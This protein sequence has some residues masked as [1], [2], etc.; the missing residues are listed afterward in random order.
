MAEAIRAHAWVGTSLGAIGSWSDTLLTQV[1]LVLCCPFP[2]SLSWGDELL[3]FCN[4]AAIEVLGERSGSA[5]GCSYR[6][7]FREAWKVQGT[8]IED[9]FAS[10]H[11]SK[12]DNVLMALGQGPNWDDRYW[13]YLLMPVHED[14][15]VVGVLSIFQDTTGAVLSKLRLV[16]ERADLLALFEQAPVTISVMEGPEHVYQ[17][18]NQT[19]RMMIGTRDV[20]G[21]RV[22]DAIPEAEEQ[23]Y[24]QI[25]NEVYRTGKAHRE[26]GRRLRLQRAP[27][28]DPEVLY[29]DFVY[30]PLRDVDGRV[31]GIISLGI[32]VSERQRA[33]EALIQA[34][35]LAAVGRLASSIAHEINNP[36]AAAVNYLYLAEMSEDLGEIRQYLSVVER[37]LKRVS[38]I[39]GQTLLSQKQAMSLSSIDVQE[40]VE[41]ILPLYLGPIRN[42]KVTVETRYRAERPLVCAEG[43]IRQVLGNLL[44]NAIDAMHEAGG[45][46][47]VRGAEVTD[48]TTGDKVHRMTVADTGG[49]ILPELMKD[50]FKPFFTTKGFAGNGLGLWI[51]EEITARHHGRIRVRSNPKG[52][53]FTVSLPRI[54]DQKRV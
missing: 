39:S 37:E 16:R 17:R 44:S 13:E 10:G 3:L 42:A 1:N 46:L 9:C 29:V 19:H 52:S 31:C 23:G 33:E 50:I 40:L 24:L 20:L 22:I 21:K 35:K 36:L 43:E 54:P 25:L 5:L 49:G 47:V 28:H 32:D 15:Q 41:S 7:V 12:H 48:W 27:G 14:G 38:A 18:V 11:A 53:V 51:C 30:Q 6:D 4:D 2:A 8:E 26:G 45:R 34:E